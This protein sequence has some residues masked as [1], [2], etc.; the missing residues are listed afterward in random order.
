[1]AAKADNFRYRTFYGSSIEQEIPVMLTTIYKKWLT[2]LFVLIYLL[3]GL[4]TA[5]ASFWCHEEENSSRL[6][7]N[8]IGQCWTSCNRVDANLPHGEETATT[9]SLLSVLDMDCLDTPVYSSTI[10]RSS[11]TSPL[12]KTG[13]ANPDALYPSY[14]PACSSEPARLTNVSSASRL[15]TP[16]VLT[17]LRTVVLLH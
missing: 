16:Q 3:L 17:T 15:P 6:E 7:F 2:R 11:R 13:P 9:E 1:M 12:S 5:N 14:N 10:L 8:S 4:S